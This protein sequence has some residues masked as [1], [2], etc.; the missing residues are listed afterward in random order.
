MTTTNSGREVLNEGRKA[1]KSLTAHASRLNPYTTLPTSHATLDFHADLFARVF[2]GPL[3]GRIKDRLRL[4]AVQ[5]QI[6]DAADAASPWLNRFFK[7]RK[8][9]SKEAQAM[10]K[11]LAPL[12]EAIGLD[13]LANPNISVDALSQR[14]LAELPVPKAIR[15]AD[16]EAEFRVAAQ[17]VIQVL[18]IVAPV[19]L[20]WQRAKFASTF[21]PAR[22]IVLRLHQISEQMDAL[23][24]HVSTSSADERFELGY[25]DYL[26]QRFF[27]VDVGMIRAATQ[28]DVDLRELFVM[29]RLGPVRG[30]IQRSHKLMNLT[31]AREAAQPRIA[32]VLPMLVAEIERVGLDQWLDGDFEL[33]FD[34]NKVQPAL[35]EALAQPRMVLV[36]A[37][38]GGKSALLEWLQVQLAGADVALIANDQQAIPLLLRVRQLDVN[39]LS[40]TAGAA[41][42]ASA[43]NSTDRAALMPA[44]WLERQMLAGRVLLM[45][46]GLDECE[47]T[48]RDQKLLPWLHAVIVRYPDCRYLIASRPVGYAPETLLDL[49]FV[50]RGLCEFDDAQ[51]ADYARHWCTAVRLARHE[52]EAEARREG[53]ADGARIVAGFAHDSTLRSLAHSPL[54]LSAICLVNY[55]E[56]GELPAQPGVLYRL[57]VEGLLHHWDAR[58]GIR[59]AFSLEEKMEV[60]REVALAMQADDRAEYTD[61]QVLRIFTATLQDAARARKLLEY[62]RQR[63]G[64]LIERRPGVFAFAHL[65]FQ[66]YLAQTKAA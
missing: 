3:T 29:P 52:G 34:A 11:G 6:E 19:L 25:R 64:L 7:N 17:S 28:V 24:R 40:E 22:K 59:S 30:P 8:L 35:D 36:G 38:G 63:T 56:G 23:T 50:E 32:K 18:M 39:A 20:E 46:D 45:L 26:L 27:R 58:R 48:L 12:A 61:Q 49:G 62:I 47:P 13:E 55:F 43:T 15:S 14:V 31:A 4:R 5:R 57:C 21:E 2:A 9:G 33:A 65:T 41:W 1:N 60:C 54:L 53:A 66:E 10:L 37:P 51:I 42:I 16:K 44:G